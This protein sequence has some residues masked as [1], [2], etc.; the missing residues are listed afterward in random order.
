MS[1]LRRRKKN[2]KVDNVNPTEKDE[3]AEVDSAELSNE[4]KGHAIWL[5][6][7]IVLGIFIAVFVGIRYAGYMK[8]LHENDM[9]FSNI[10]VGFFN[11]WKSITFYMAVTA[12]FKF[13]YTTNSSIL[14]TIDHRCYN[15]PVFII[16][17]F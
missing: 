1:E 8:Q 5:Y 13:I 3:V 4:K 11:S 2:A 6:F 12:I 14:I 10:K 9:W 15:I 7:N 17:L 16:Q